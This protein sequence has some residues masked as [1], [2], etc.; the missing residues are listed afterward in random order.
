MCT[1][2]SSAHKG[3]ICRAKFMRQVDELV[4]GEF[5]QDVDS[6]AGDADFGIISLIRLLF[7]D[8][9]PLET[10]KIV[11]ETLAQYGETLLNYSTK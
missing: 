11:D 7:L 10:K 3:F 2:K 4:L 6:K 5:L 8:E 1:E 9:V